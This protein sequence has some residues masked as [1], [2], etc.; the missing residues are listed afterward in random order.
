MTTLPRD[1][2]AFLE[3]YP[4]DNSDDELAS[5]NLE[6]YRNRRKCQPDNVLVSEIHEG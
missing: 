1:I 2:R 4:G 3:N 6:F 5:A